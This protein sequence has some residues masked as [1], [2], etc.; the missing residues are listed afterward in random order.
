MPATLMLERNSPY[1]MELRR[2]TFDVLVDG[3]RIG[4][5]DS[6]DTMDAPV[7]AGRHTLRVREGRYTSKE[8]AFEADDGEVVRFRC[9][10]AKIWPIWL[11]T[12]VVPKLALSLSRER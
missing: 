5:I 10:G 1:V 6:R 8:L 3:D 11:A 2:G 7:E 9:S 4:S 12:F